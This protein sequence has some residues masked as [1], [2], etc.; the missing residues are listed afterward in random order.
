MAD[1]II[2]PVVAPEPV[3]CPWGTENCTICVNGKL[4]I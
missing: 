4:E 3:I 2:E 1:D